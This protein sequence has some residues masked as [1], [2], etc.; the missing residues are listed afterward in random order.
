MTPGPRAS[1][2]R[3]AQFPVPPPGSWD[4]GRTITL[5]VAQWRTEKNSKNFFLG[6]LAVLMAIPLAYFPAM[7]S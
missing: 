1:G 6:I 5:E 7:R 4:E 2:G 3:V